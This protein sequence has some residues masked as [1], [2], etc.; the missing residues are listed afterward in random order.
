MEEVLATA[1][2]NAKVD[3]SLGIWTWEIAFYLFL[4]G[5]AAG[6]ML[7]A[8]WAV[9]GCSSGGSSG[10]TLSDSGAGADP[11]P[12]QTG[13]DYT[14]LADFS[15]YDNWVCDNDTI[16]DPVSG[17]TLIPEV[18]IVDDPGT[19]QRRVTGNSIPDHLVGDFPNVSNPNEI[20][21]FDVT[22]DM[23][24][25]VATENPDRTSANGAQLVGISVGGILFDPM[26]AEVYNNDP[27]SE[28]RYEALTIGV[29]ANTGLAGAIGY[30]GS[31]CNNAHVQPTGKYHYHGMPEEL[32]S[33]L[34]LAAG[35]S[36]GDPAMVMVGYAADGFPMYA[37]Y[38]Y[39]DPLDASSGIVSLE[40]SYEL[41]SGTR[42]SGPG[43]SYDGTFTNDWE[44]V[45]DSGDLDECNGRYGVTPEYPNGIYHYYVTDDYP[46]IQRC[47][48]GEPTDDALL[49]GPPP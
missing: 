49:G 29:A 40:G 12:V 33:D 46:F 45:A 34:L 23:V 6:I 21:E 10:T 14:Q 35:G 15:G 4:G 19:L 16:F 3:P 24:M 31:D 39:A 28:W 18:D 38:G 11:T 44:Y 36:L 41:K 26:T 47:V 5:M 25:R 30:L 13:V 48:W 17:A 42:P 27:G 8:A 37:R 43:G 20:D 32:V 9:T 1:R 7:F 2:Y 22:Y